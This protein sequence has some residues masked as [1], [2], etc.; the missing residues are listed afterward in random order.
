MTRSKT[1]NPVRSVA[2]VATCLLAVGLATGL[3]AC[4]GDRTDKRPR[5]FFPGMDDQ[6]RFKAQ[7]STEFFADGRSMRQPVQGTVPFGRAVLVGD[8]PWAEA[9][10][11]RDELVRADP[12]AYTGRNADGTWL[13]EIPE[14]VVVDAA[15]LEIGQ[16]GFNIYCA[17]CHGDAGDGQGMVGKR[18]SYPVPS[19]YDPK[20]ADRAL[21]TG[22]DGYL[23]HVVRQGVYDAQGV[24]KMPGYAHAISETEAWGVVAYLRAL[25]TSR[26]GTLEDVPAREAEILKQK[27]P[28]PQASVAPEASDPDGGDA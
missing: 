10:A 2:R 24:Q 6:P 20:Y 13:A 7:D 9:L 22:K 4:R 11:E 26:T 17:A 3:V 8:Q 28:A 5:Q 27:S 15:L 19:F 14:S 21:D 25:Q 12:L 16:S 23:W 1:S 18:W